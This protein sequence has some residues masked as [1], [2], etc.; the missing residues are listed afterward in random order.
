MRKSIKLLVACMLCSPVAIV[1]QE[2]DSLFARKSKVAIE[3]GRGISFNLKES[4]TATAV[5]SEEELSHKKSINNSNML[6]GLIP[7]LQ[8]LQNSGNAWDDA[9]TLRVRGYGTSSSTTP[10]VLVDGFERSLDQISA[11]EIES[12]TVLKDAASTA[13]YGMKGANGVILITTKSAKTEKAKVTFDAKW[14]SNS[15]MVPQYDVIGTAEYYETQYKTL[16]NSKIYTGSSKAEAYNYADKTLL[17][18]KNGGLGYLVY[19]VPD[20]EKLIGNNFKLNPN[21]KLGYSDGKYYYTPDD[22]YDEVFSSNFRQE[23][24]V[25]I[26]GRSDKL[27]YYASVGYLN[28]SGIIQNSAYKRYT[29]RAKVDYQ[30]KEWLK[31]GT[32]IAYTY[33]DSQAPDYQDGDSWGSS[34]NLFYVSNTIAP[35]CT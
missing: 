15:R 26:S 28:D 11:D 17:D 35:I 12:V 24:N 9:A 18:A 13:L 32:N 21:A 3:Y 19:T 25:N 20:G 4:T 23:Y 29:G 10:L 16:Y 1:A 34:A 7:G 27:N 22:W 2:Q 31:V 14:G 33:S 8:V 5:A 6:Y 30:A